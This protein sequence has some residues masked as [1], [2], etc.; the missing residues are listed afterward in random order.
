MILVWVCLVKSEAISP[1]G[2]W[3]YK[4]VQAVPAELESAEWM[5]VWGEMLEFCRVN[6]GYQ[7]LQFLR[8]PDESPLTVKVP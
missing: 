7:I 1:K 3:A 5:R 6:A 8:E 4:I 2:Y